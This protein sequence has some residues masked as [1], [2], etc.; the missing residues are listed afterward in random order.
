[1]KTKSLR[2]ILGVLILTSSITALAQEPPPWSVLAQNRVSN[3]K[4]VWV[5]MYNMF[6]SVREARC[7]RDGDETLF[8]GYYPPLKY[9]IRAEVKANVDCGGATIRDFRNEVDLFRG[10]YAKVISYNDQG[11]EDYMWKI[12]MGPNAAA[13]TQAVVPQFT[14]EVFEKAEQIG[15]Q[16]KGGSTLEA[17]NGLTDKTVWVTIYNFF[18]SI[19]DSGCVQPGQK[20][21]WDNYYDM[22]LA[23]S[24]RFE[25]KNGVNCSGDTIYDNGLGISDIH[26]TKGGLITR[27]AVRGQEKYVLAPYER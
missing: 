1:M 12:S 26:G 19:R 5:T 21:G 14:K 15:L 16:S 6:D 24:M 3:G 18:G 25:V 13:P 22:G 9:Y 10:A 4:S 8:S 23:Y 11:R 2:N 17:Q 27:E 20:R 7:V